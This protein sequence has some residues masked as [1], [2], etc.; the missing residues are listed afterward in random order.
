[1]GFFKWLLFKKFLKELFFIFYYTYYHKLGAKALNGSLVPRTLD[2]NEGNQM[3]GPK[4]KDTNS[5]VW[6][7]RVPIAGTHHSR[8]QILDVNMVTKVQV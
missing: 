6:N 5:R 3:L 7:V 2:L 8:T 1:M 4:Y